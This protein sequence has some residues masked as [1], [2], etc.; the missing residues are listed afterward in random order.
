MSKPNIRYYFRY[1]DEMTLERGYLWKKINCDFKKMRV[2]IMENKIRELY[3][4]DKNN[5][6][7]RF[8]CSA[9]S[10]AIFLK[11]YDGC[12]ELGLYENK[13]P[14][15][16]DL[17]MEV[18]YLTSDC[19]IKIPIE[20]SSTSELLNL[21]DRI[22][23]LC[24]VSRIFLSDTAIPKQFL[25]RNKNK[26]LSLVTIMKDNKLFYEKYGY[27]I[28][29]I[30]SVNPI[31]FPFSENNIEIPKQLLR[32]FPYS[33]FIHLLNEKDTI[34]I[35]TIKK[36]SKNTKIY[37][38]LYKCFNDYYEFL[39]TNIHED[40]SMS[41]LFNEFIQIFYNEKYPWF[42]MIYSIHSMKYCMNKI[43]F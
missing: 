25:S 30:Q 13:L 2:F 29:D 38:K 40:E 3:I 14:I 15:S 35:D 23:N 7:Y 9:S 31:L 4:S 26:F 24:N 41:V 22:A 28:C 18:R 17:E 1:H 19:F 39:V 20:K 6:E 27:S 43:I 33:V 5:A 42:S 21:V 16:V 10:D 12:L 8:I 11:D 37:D 36:K 32:N 34:V